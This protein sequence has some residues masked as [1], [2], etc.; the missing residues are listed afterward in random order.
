MAE[1]S[2]KKQTFVVHK[3]QADNTPRTVAA[4]NANNAGVAKKKVVVVKKRPAGPENSAPKPEN[5]KKDGVRVVVK[6]ADGS[7][8]KQKCPAAGSKTCCAETG[9]FGAEWKP[10]FS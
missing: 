7:C 4:S 9:R 8:W 3:K 6:K 5:A 2:E 1:E 10:V